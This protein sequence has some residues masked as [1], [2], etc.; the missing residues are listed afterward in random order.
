MVSFKQY[1]FFITSLCLFFVFVSGAVAATSTDAVNV[2]LN[3][4]GC[5]NNL[6]CEP[7]TGEDEITCPLDCLDPGV[8]ATT[9]PPSIQGGGI[10]EQQE[11]ELYDLVVRPTSNSAIITFKSTNPSIAAVGWGITGDYEKG[12]TVTINPHTTFVVVLPSLQADQQYQFIIVLN[13]GEQ[14]YLHTSS[15]A[16]LPLQNEIVLPDPVRNLISLQENNFVELTWDNP[17][18]FDFIRVM[19]RTD[20]H[21]L[22]PF[23]GEIV[24]EGSGE[25]FSDSV[26]ECG[27]YAVFVRYGTRYSSGVLTTT[28]QEDYFVA[29]DLNTEILSETDIVFLQQGQPLPDELGRVYYDPTEQVTVRALRL[30]EVS[31][32]RY[33]LVLDSKTRMTTITH[34]L[35]YNDETDAYEANLGTGE[36]IEYS[37]YV[38]FLLSRG[39]LVGSLSGFLSPDRSAGFSVLSLF[40]IQPLVIILLFVIL[41]LL[42]FFWTNRRKRQ[43]GDSYTVPE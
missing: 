6:I 1:S 4:E 39:E 12:S 31:Q 25:S 18:V 33:V 7:G 14:Q 42:V 29:D 32:P 19:H 10:W 20:R 22:S 8:V 35:Q 43:K 2:E 5:N 40:D 9:T 17:D 24:Y 38:L 41:S 26:V 23:D 16:T 37:E 30:P 21:P 34:V 13:D 3:V 36:D 11:L 27:Y 28:C 15:F